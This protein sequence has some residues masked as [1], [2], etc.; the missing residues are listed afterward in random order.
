M[1]IVDGIV[2]KNVAYSL[3]KETGRPSATFDIAEICKQAEVRNAF[4]EIV[5]SH[6]KCNIGYS[7]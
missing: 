5:S 3:E 6:L 4:V 1:P 2:W 7:P